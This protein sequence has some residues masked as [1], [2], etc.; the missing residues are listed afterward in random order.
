M[1]KPASTGSGA[2]GTGSAARLALWFDHMVTRASGVALWLAV[3]CLAAL[4]AIVLVQVA[5]GL[6]STQLPQ[7]SRMMSASW[8][9]AGY[10][11]GAAFVLAMPATLRAGGHIRVTLLRDHLSPR[12]AHLADMVA[13]LL[14]VIMLSHLAQALLTRAIQSFQ[15]GSVS[16]ASLTP[17]WLPEAA[18]AIAMALF[19][20]Q[21]LARFFSLLTGQEAEFQR[22]LVDTP[23]E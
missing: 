21:A 15:S 5:T 23:T 1:R 11:M 4:L 20:L 2:A 8:E 17:L 13:S 19:A 12:G 6:L 22:D 3:A 9:H 14:A 18:F 10:L 16:T 7:L